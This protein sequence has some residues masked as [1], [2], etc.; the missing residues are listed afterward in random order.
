MVKYQNECPT[1]VYFTNGSIT[2]MGKCENNSF[3]FA[4]N[5][6]LLMHSKWTFSLSRENANAGIFS[7]SFS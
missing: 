7:F 1:W 6:Q 2:L 5:N 3:I 4:H